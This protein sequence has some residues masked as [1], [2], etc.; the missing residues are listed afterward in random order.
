MFKMSETSSTILED[1]ITD[2]LLNTVSF[3]S[4]NTRSLIL[5]KSRETEKK[6]CG[7]TRRKVPER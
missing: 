6:S 1:L 7:K 2:L 4:S 3:H 5:N